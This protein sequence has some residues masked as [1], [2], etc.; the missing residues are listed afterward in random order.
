M[1]I[2]D[3]TSA[4]DACTSIADRYRSSPPPKYSFHLERLGAGP[5]LRFEPHSDRTPPFLVP[6]AAA[7]AALA[8]AY[9]QCQ[10]DSVDR[11]SFNGLLT[12]ARCTTLCRLQPTCPAHMDQVSRAP[13]GFWRGERV[14]YDRLPLR[15]TVAWYALHPTITA[16]P[17]SVVF[18]GGR[19]N[20]F[21]AL[22]AL[23]AERHA[24]V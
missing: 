1:D 13:R 9:V 5:A 20:K 7:L 2:H 12:I 11:C 23:L 16:L 19:Q 15:A 24:S 22:C 14:E 4:V 17:E 3:C 18:S 8:T 10:F 6:A 21:G